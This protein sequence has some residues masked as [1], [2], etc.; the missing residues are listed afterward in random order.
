MHWILRSVSQSVSKL[1]SQLVSSSKNQ[2]QPPITTSDELGEWAKKWIEALPV[3]DASPDDDG[4]AATGGADAEEQQIIRQRS[5][6]ALE[7]VD[8]TK[9]DDVHSEGAADGH[10][11]DIHK[12]P[13]KHVMQNMPLRCMKQIYTG[14]VGTARDPSCPMQKLAMSSHCIRSPY[15]VQKL[16]ITIADQALDYAQ[17]ASTVSGIQIGADGSMWFTAPKPTTAVEAVSQEVVTAVTEEVVEP[18]EEA[19]EEADEDIA[20]AAGASASKR[21]RLVPP[22]AKKESKP[23]AKSK[24]AAKQAPGQRLLIMPTKPAA[25]SACKLAFFGVVNSCESSCCV[26]IGEL[27]VTGAESDKL[28][29]FMHGICTPN[30]MWPSLA[31]LMNSSADDSDVTM[32]ILAESKIV[33]HSV[34]NSTSDV[35]ICLPYLSLKDGVAAQYKEGDLIPLIRPVLPSEQ[36]K[37][38][39]K[40]T[41]AYLRAQSMLDVFERSP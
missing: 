9:P 27:R 35:E 18:V 6:I 3:P 4:T 28:D 41:K 19:P 32:E 23:K 40:L 1:V 13:F 21:R 25:A 8:V 20:E 30:S 14:Q 26:S 16:F 11:A 34:G 39:S 31:F 33:K 12:V 7:V 15:S 22:K 29:I 2:A 5:A 24:A 36:I 17:T 10:V 37:S 38:S